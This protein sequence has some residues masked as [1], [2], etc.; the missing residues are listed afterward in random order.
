MDTNPYQKNPAGRLNQTD[1][2]EL[3]KFGVGLILANQY[4]DQLKPEIR[5]AVTGN[6]GTLVSFRLSARDAPS[7]A[8]ELSPTFEPLDLVKLPNY[9]MYLK[10]MIDG[11]PSRPFSAFSLRPD[12]VSKLRFYRFLNSSRWKRHGLPGVYG[13]GNA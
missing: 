5:N 11:M 7:V 1:T 9:E 10:L 4:L 3:R 13:D 2:S 8:R 6:A 12:E